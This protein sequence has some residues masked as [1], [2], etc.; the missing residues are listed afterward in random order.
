M[1]LLNEENKQLFGE[2]VNDHIAKL[3]DLMAHGPG[4]DIDADLIHKTCFANRL[5]EG[6]TRMIGLTRWSFT[7]EMFRELLEKSSRSGRTW[8]EQLS[9]I[10]SEILEAEEQFIAEI[11]TGGMELIEQM[12]SFGGLQEE[13]KVLLNESFERPDNAT[14]GEGE[15]SVGIKDEAAKTGDRSE[16]EQYAP[17]SDVSPDGGNHFITLERLIKSLEKVDQR[18]LDC[19]E[20][21]DQDTGSL[22]DLEL[23]FGE[24]EFFLGLVGNILRLW[25]ERGRTFKSKVAS[26]TLLDG[27]EDFMKMQGRLRN[28]K[29]K[30]R[31]SADNFSMERALAADLAVALESCIFDIFRMH[32]EGDGLEVE[33]NMELVN[34][35]SYLVAK[36]SDNGPDF[37]C[38]SEIDSQD[39]VAYYPSLLKLRGILRNLNCL[40]WVEPDKGRGGRFSFTYPRTT[41]MTDYRIFSMSGLE[42]AVPSHCVD[43]VVDKGE[44]IIEPDP[45]GGYLEL[46]GS[47][48]PVC[49]IDELA[50]EE[51]DAGEE[52]SHIAVLGLAEKRIGIFVEGEGG[53]MEGLFEQHTEGEWASLSRRYLHFG[54]REYP[55]LDISLTLE[56][57]DWIQ[58]LNGSIEESS[59]FVDEVRDGEEEKI[60]RV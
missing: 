23:A 54:E 53:K 37:L 5:L 24:S 28:W 32:E 46:N 45:T 58:E 8:D 50:P 7:L 1:V 19:L 36:I 49:R 41:V 3:N 42:V 55:I 59:S 11:V 57:Y 48:V 29:T 22:R 43:C 30:L 35:G 4:W 34:R 56:R 31:S 60:S 47:R 40:L 38:D 13:L 20:Q 44:G 15:I 12:D 17:E 21:P 9:Q 33:V 25:G 6:S 2:Q 39:P 16:P 18:L 14:S 27:I 51:I 10:V 26:G 52:G